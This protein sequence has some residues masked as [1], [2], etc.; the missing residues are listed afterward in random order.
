MILYYKCNKL[1]NKNSSPNRDHG[2][3]F[4]C[5]TNITEDGLHTWGSRMWG[6]CSQERACIKDYSIEE[7]KIKFFLEYTF[8]TECKK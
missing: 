2:K 6:Y 1:T 4:W 5:S 8:D 3:R 7:E